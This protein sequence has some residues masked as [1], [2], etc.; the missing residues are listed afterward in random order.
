MREFST[1][2]IM[3]DLQ[4]FG[5]KLSHRGAAPGRC[6][7]FSFGW[8]NCLDPFAPLYRRH[9]RQQ[10]RIPHATVF[11]YCCMTTFLGR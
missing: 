6:P 10:P 1:G 11:Q 5:Q 3:T 8:E 7:W 4:G 9:A 2:S